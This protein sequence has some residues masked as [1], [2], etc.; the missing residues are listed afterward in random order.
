MGRA[1]IGYYVHHQG[2][3]HLQRMLAIARHL[4]EPV[5]AL[6][7]LPAPD[8]S[9]PWVDLP[10]DNEAD[11]F[12]DPTANGTLHWAPR[13]DAGLRRRMA[14]IARWIED[15]DPDLMVVDVSVEVATLSRLLGVPTVVV[16]MRGDRFDRAHRTAYDA[17]DA[18]L[19]AWPAEFAVFDWPISWLRKAFHAGAITRFAGRVPAPPDNTGG[20]PRVLVLWGAGGAGRPNAEIAAA[21]AAAPDWEWRVANAPADEPDAL[22]DQLSWA[23]VVVTHG[24]QNAVAEVA[25][26]RRPAVIIA[27]SRPHAEQ[28]ETA[29]AL[30]DAGLAVGLQGWPEHG[31]WPGLLES[32]HAIGGAGWGRWVSGNAAADAAAF[33][34]TMARAVRRDTD[35]AR[36][37]TSGVMA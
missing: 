3:G 22:W 16:A 5:T 28:A 14:I 37:G 4:D 29:R 8:S 11:G 12:V 20:S 7:S 36:T 27:E 1:M 17:A 30:A 26:A 35:A 33:L 15:C 13:H 2:R 24:G 10:M 6:S 34:D 9:W 18:L 25:A 21:A 23:D 31:R 32:A 19:A